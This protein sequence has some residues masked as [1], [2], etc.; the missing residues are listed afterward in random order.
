[1]ERQRVN[2]KGGGRGGYP[3]VKGNEKLLTSF[4]AL[5]RD[6]TRAF[7]KVRTTAGR[8]RRFQSAVNILGMPRVLGVRTQY[9]RHQKLEGVGESQEGGKNESWNLE[10]NKRGGEKGEKRRID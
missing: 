6:M 9:E 7:E 8:R 3:G 1:L 10:T 5:A 2:L 4:Q